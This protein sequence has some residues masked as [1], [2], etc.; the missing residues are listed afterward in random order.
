MRCRRDETPLRPFLAKPLGAGGAVR[1]ETGPAPA[2][3]EAGERAGR[4]G[5]GV[6]LYHK[7]TNRA[8][9]DGAPGGADV[10]ETILWN[11]E[12]R[13][14]KPHANIVAAIGGRRSSRRRSTAG[15][16]AG[17]FRAE[18]LERGDLPKGRSERRIA[19]CGPPLWLIN[20]VQGWRQ[21]T[22]G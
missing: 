7:T 18:L 6:A 22:A 10:D 20:S 13:S 16:L 21:P 2:G 17:T 14:R 11:E 9:Y 3:G 1:L 15:L 19:G 5:N 4:V 8:I 12:A